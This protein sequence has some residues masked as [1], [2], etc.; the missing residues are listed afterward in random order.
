MNEGEALESAGVSRIPTGKSMDRTGFRDG[1]ITAKYMVSCT[2]SRKT[3]W[4]YECDCGGFKVFYS[5]CT[6]TG[7]CGCL[8]G[9]RMSAR[10]VTHGASRSRVYKA[11]AGMKDRCYNPKN[12]A[13]PRYGGRGISVC[14]RWRRSFA[15]FI[16][17]MGTRPPGRT[18]ERIDN[19]GNYEPG[20]CRWA[21]RKEQ[22]SNRGVCSEIEFGGK[23]QC[24][25]A[26]SEE[27]GIPH[28]TL[29]GRILR[30]WSI[31]EAFETPVNLKMRNGRSKCQLLR[32]SQSLET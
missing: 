25:M 8:T 15:D 29:R 11:W 16:E 5:H 13:Y 27:F 23:S 17:G 28:Q 7:H 1:L 26:W 4:M 9:F 3:K 20:N 22:Q 24:L 2:D 31:M 12:Q 19:D 6:R 30:G 10:F 14:D 32:K 21:T 18:I